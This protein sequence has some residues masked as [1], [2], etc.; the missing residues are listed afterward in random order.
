[1][2]LQ[3]S[4]AFRL[5]LGYA[6]G[7]VGGAALSA[8]PE[9]P[10]TRGLSMYN[11]AKTIG[12][13]F[14]KAPETPTEAVGPEGDNALGGAQMASGL[15]P[16]GVGQNPYNINTMNRYMTLKYGGR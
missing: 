3:N 15:D 8:M 10:V 2:A 13:A 7:G 11:N 4:K 6:T 5:G 9:S 1:M 12:S 14:S 16:Y